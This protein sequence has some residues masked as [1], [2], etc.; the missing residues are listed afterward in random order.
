[1]HKYSLNRPFLFLACG[2]QTLYGLISMG[3]A[4]LLNAVATTVGNAGT[5]GELLRVGL[6]AIAYGLVYAGSRALADCVVQCYCERNAQRLRERL[7]RAVF[8]MDSARFAEQDTGD[9]LNMMTADVLLVREQYDSQLPL[10]FCY[11]SQFVFCVGY[12]LILNPVVAA[13]LMGMSVIQYFVPSLFGGLINRRMVV[14]S[15]Q[16]ARF[17]SKAK[18][19]LLGF[20]VIKSYGAEEGIRNEFDAVNGEMTK[21]RERA[22]VLTWIM[23]SSNMMIGW[24]M[25]LLSVVVAGCFVVSGTMPVG[26]I[27]TVFYIANRYSMPVMDFAAAYTKI[28]GSRG[29]REKLYGFLNE[30]PKIPA[31]EGRSVQNGITL[32][33][34]SFSYDGDADVLRQV[35]FTFETGKKYLLLGESG[36][37][38]STLLKL[39]AG[40]YPSVGIRVDGIPLEELPEG[41]LRGHIILVGQQ[42]YVFHRTVADN[43]DF[44]RTGE[45]ARLLETAEKCRVTDFLSAFSH[46]IDTMVDEEQRQ[47]SG[48]QKA[49]IGLARAIYTGPD[50]LLL[51]EVTSA[52]DSQT[53]REIEQMILDLE[54]ILVIHVAHKP[55]RELMEQYDAVLEFSSGL[56]TPLQSP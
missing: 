16:T 4:V 39:I 23:M 21:S 1:M 17:T 42:P 35:S 9:Y 56:C 51:D 41:A 38:K 11:I 52:L 55:C 48:G 13:V 40:Q 49:R 29:M 50:V 36:S 7:N 15:E 14:Q 2:L 18:E 10:L 5:I 31:A 24:I 34:L 25:V 54:D 33:D 6:P 43:I 47:I 19:L 28:K 22:S 32:Q 8:S 46:G 27:L 3:A 26:S 53:A 37:G 12:S 45:R 44:L 20:S 30:H